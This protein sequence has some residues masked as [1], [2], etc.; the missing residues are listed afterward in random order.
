MS[1]VLKTTDFKL[2][3]EYVALK[4]WRCKRVGSIV[5]EHP[6]GFFSAVKDYIWICAQFDS[7]D[8]AVAGI[9]DVTL[10]EGKWLAWPHLDSF[11]VKKGGLSLKDLM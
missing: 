10:A 1:K 11:G 3:N 8:A 2:C 9:N 4:V 6:D 7:L 5:Y